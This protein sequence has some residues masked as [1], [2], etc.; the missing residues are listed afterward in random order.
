L[1]LGG[2]KYLEFKLM[3]PVAL[4]VTTTEKISED[5]VFTVIEKV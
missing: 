1:V 2:G 4:T 5:E 3:R